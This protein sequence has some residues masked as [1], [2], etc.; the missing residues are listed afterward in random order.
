MKIKVF[1]L[2][3]TFGLSLILSGCSSEYDPNPPKESPILSATFPLKEQWSASLSGNESIYSRLTPAIYEDEIYV[4][5]RSGEVK[6]FDLNTGK[7]I[8]QTQLNQSGFLSQENAQLSS[9]VV[10]DEDSIVIGS[11][12]GKLF[13]LNRAFGTVNW[14]KNVSGELLAKAAIAQGK[15][16]TQTSNGI[17]QIRDASSGDLIWQTSINSQSLT[18]RGNAAPLIA[19]D[20]VIVGSANGR[21]MAYT[22]DSG[23]LVWQQRLSQPRGTN[24]I[25]RLSDVIVTPQ[26]DDN[27]IYAVGYNGYFAALDLNTGA[28]IWR[29]QLSSTTPFLITDEVIYLI[30]DHS[31]I[32]AISKDDG[33][34]LWVQSD[35]Q[36]RRLTAPALLNDRLYVADFEGFMYEVDLESG[37]LISKSELNSSGF[38]SAPMVADNRLI[39]QAKNGKLM[40]LKTK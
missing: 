27:I 36:N 20:K 22:L 7:T 9:G 23:E 24:E 17:L 11:E 2:T 39:I 33:K 34:Q 14:E 15:I 5:G 30:D 16:A 25:A 18:L 4:A 40:I 19:R 13:E 35:L 31:Q 12:K 8:W 10:L 32:L 28:E 26:I 38:L 3:A 29:A 6:A 21:L 1:C 37:A